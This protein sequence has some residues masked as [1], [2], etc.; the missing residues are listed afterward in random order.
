MLDRALGPNLV[1]RLRLSAVVQSWSWG[2]QVPD[3]KMTY[4]LDCQQAIFAFY[5]FREP[6][7]VSLNDSVSHFNDNE[8]E[9]GTTYSTN[10]KN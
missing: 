10:W 5:S 7:W 1:T 3:K 8:N 4:L 9:R 6:V 2:N